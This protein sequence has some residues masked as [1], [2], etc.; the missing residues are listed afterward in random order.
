[1]WTSTLLV[2]PSLAQPRGCTLTSLAQPRGRRPPR[3]AIAGPNRGFSRLHWSAEP[4]LLSLFWYK[5]GGKL[6][7]RNSMTAR[8]LRRVSVLRPAPSSC[9]NSK[10]A[11]TLRRVSVLRPAPSS[12]RDRGSNRGRRPPRV[13]IAGSNRGFSRLDW[14]AQPTLLESLSWCQS[15]G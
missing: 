10:T 15:S 9:R 8:T 4:T 5:P 11:R 7:C 14:S 3:V 1:M 13:A 6:T 2:S 12:C